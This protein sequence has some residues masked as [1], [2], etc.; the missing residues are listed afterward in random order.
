VQLANPVAT[1][2]V[3]AFLLLLAGSVLATTPAGTDWRVVSSPLVVTAALVLYAWGGM[4]VQ[5]AGW[6]DTMHGV[7]GTVHIQ[8][9]VEQVRAAL[10]AALEAEGRA[11]VFA[12]GETLVERRTREPLA[13]HELLAAVPSSP[14]ERWKL[15]RRGPVR[16]QPGV[17]FDAVGALDGSLTVLSWDA[18]MVQDGLGD[19]EGWKRAVEELLE[20]VRREVEAK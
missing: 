12:I 13:R 10:A 4:Q 14:F 1:L 17:V 3:A 20:G 6:P 16:R 2:M 8:G 19:G 15:E 18:G 9:D 7:G 5:Q 11:F